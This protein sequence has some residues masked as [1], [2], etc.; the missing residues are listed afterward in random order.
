MNADVE[1]LKGQAYGLL[2]SVS[3][4]AFNDYNEAVKKQ[5]FERV[6]QEIV[7]A[8]FDAR[9]EAEIGQAQDMTTQAKGVLDEVLAQQQDTDLQEKLQAALVDTARRDKYGHFG[10]PGL[11]AGLEAHKTAYADALHLRDLAGDFSAIPEIERAKLDSHALAAR[12]KLLDSYQT[13]TGMTRDQANERVSEIFGDVENPSLF[14]DVMDTV[15]DVWE[16]MV[17]PD[18]DQE[19]DDR[20]ILRK[21]GHAAGWFVKRFGEKSMWALGVLDIPQHIT[22][23]GAGAGA[24]LGQPLEVVRERYPEL[25]GALQEILMIQNKEHPSEEETDRAKT[26]KEK[27]RDFLE[28][29]GAPVYAM[30]KEGVKST[31]DAFRG[32]HS[33]KVFKQFAANVTD[34][35]AYQRF[36]EG[37]MPFSPLLPV[38]GAEMQAAKVASKATYEFLQPTFWSRTLDFIV[39]GRPSAYMSRSD[40]GRNVAKV[41]MVVADEMVRSAREQVALL[42]YKPIIFGEA[43]P[44]RPLETA[45]GVVHGRTDTAAEAAA[46]EAASRPAPKPPLG[47]EYKPTVFGDPSPHVAFGPDGK[48]LRLAPGNVGGDS[49]SNAVHGRNPVYVIDR[50]QDVAEQFRTAIETQDLSNTFVREGLLRAVQRLRVAQDATPDDLSA[51][52]AIEASIRNWERTAAKDKGQATAAV[53]PPVTNAVDPELVTKIERVKERLPLIDS[54]PTNGQ[55]GEATVDGIRYKKDLTLDE[56][57]ENSY[58]KDRRSALEALGYS[59]SMLRRLV[60]TDDEARLFVLLHEEGHFIAGDPARQA[61]QWKYFSAGVPANASGRA[62][63]GQ[64]SNEREKLAMMHAL[65]Q[66]A[67]TTGRPFSNVM[68]EV[69]TPGSFARFNPETGRFSMV[70][71]PKPDVVPTKRLSADELD[72]FRQVA[73]LMD[74]SVDSTRTLVKTWG[75]LAAK[76]SPVRRGTRFHQGDAVEGIVLEDFVELGELFGLARKEG[77]ALEVYGDRVYAAFTYRYGATEKEMATRTMRFADADPAFSQPYSSAQL[78]KMEELINGLRGVKRVNAMA[79]DTEFEPATTEAALWFLSEVGNGGKSYQLVRARTEAMN[80]A[81]AET[82]THKWGVVSRP[83]SGP[84]LGTRAVETA[85][86]E[87]DVIE[88]TQP[89]P[90]GA[91]TSVDTDDLSKSGGHVWAQRDEGMLEPGIPAKTGTDFGPNRPDSR[92]ATPEDAMYDAVSLDEMRGKRVIDGRIVDDAIDTADDELGQAYDPFSAQGEPL[93]GSPQMGIAAERAPLDDTLRGPVDNPMPAMQ[94]SPEQVRVMELE[95]FAGVKLH[96]GGINS[97]MKD[98]KV[99]IF[100]TDSKMIDS[101][102]GRFMR[103]PEDRATAKATLDRFVNKQIATMANRLATGVASAQGMLLFHRA[104]ATAKAMGE[105]MAEGRVSARTAQWLDDMSLTGATGLPNVEQALLT[106]MNQALGKY[107]SQF[108]MQKNYQRV[109]DKQMADIFDSMATSPRAREAFIETYAAQLSGPEA[110]AARREINAARAVI[111]KAVGDACP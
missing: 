20:G 66:Y 46:R 61:E 69:V 37:A 19:G 92:A 38:I 43:P 26:L 78:A 13:N 4:P 49:A 18:K 3:Q 62:T 50:V 81:A 53:A 84:G 10:T 34:D 17:G 89:R 11:P 48:P 93:P 101:Q 106:G 45:E 77:E 28:T 90:R 1:Y 79:L 86:G 29:V 59:E 70:W 75:A 39:P 15:G 25:H 41:E 71:P 67:K 22:K 54:A 107:G 2:S 95:D 47:L 94:G 104:I 7:S 99:N 16:D 88:V 83:D 33:N 102:F 103:T 32:D 42:E 72:A 35:P 100:V 6:K 110:I 12:E 23:A 87:M 65:E 73:E 68:P 21:T 74:G 58:F 60:T 76:E 82:A 27:T 80:R 91:T 105:V 98:R 64:L 9:Q 24:I 109:V 85:D 55:L 56:F 31:T 111:K 63:V 108:T 30:L 8:D 44:A 96:D 51:A 36:I 52:D 57:F 14:R 97:F 40:I 5:D